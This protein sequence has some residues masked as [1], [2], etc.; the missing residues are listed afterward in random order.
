[1]TESF[2][3]HDDPVIEYQNKIIAT[4]QSG[5]RLNNPIHYDVIFPF[6]D[7]VVFAEFHMK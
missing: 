7:I 3:S 6:S 1:M 5:V 2:I 4:A